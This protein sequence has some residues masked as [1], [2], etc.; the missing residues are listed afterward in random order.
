M[1]VYHQNGNSSMWYSNTTGTYLRNLSLF[2]KTENQKYSGN[3]LFFFLLHKLKME[4][5]EEISEQI[6]LQCFYCLGNLCFIFLRKC[7]L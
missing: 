5:E 6:I 1:Q 4:S 3:T 2:I 7:L